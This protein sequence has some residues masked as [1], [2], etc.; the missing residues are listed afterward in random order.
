MTL[1]NA[2]THEWTGNIPGAG[3]TLGD[4]VH[5][6]LRAEDTAGYITMQPAIGPTMAYPLEIRSSSPP[7]TNI[8]ADM[9]GS[10]VRVMW[11]RAQDVEGLT[12]YVLFR[13]G[14][15]IAEV[16]ALEFLV[17][18]LPNLSR[19]VFQLRAAYGPALTILSAPF[20]FLTALPAS[21]LAYSYS[22]NILT[23]TWETPPEPFGRP[24]YN[25]YRNGVQINEFPFAELNF[26]DMP[27]NGANTYAVRVV[28]PTSVSDIVSLAVN[29]DGPI[30]TISHEEFD[31]GQT[32]IGTTKRQL[33]K[34]SNTGTNVIT[35]FMMRMTGEDSDVFGI[36]LQNNIPYVS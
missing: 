25:V 20:E 21:G 12:G 5:Y 9:V 29:V 22:A 36:D 16:N 15:P 4:T 31:F 14:A 27:P 7:P 33:F 28:Y 23:L 1:T 10:S 3:L 24:M 2:A 26:A 35:V 6:Y 19:S 8:R 11:D 18:D 17:P 30:F 34:I 32:P 13:N